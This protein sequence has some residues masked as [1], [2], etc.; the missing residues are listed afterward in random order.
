MTFRR[1]GTGIGDS[2]EGFPALLR[3]NLPD[4]HPQDQVVVTQPHISRIIS[5]GVRFL[6]LRDVMMV[7]NYHGP[8]IT[9]ST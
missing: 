4:L 2:C 9:V 1:R 8:Y 6:N 7:D 5:P 3:D